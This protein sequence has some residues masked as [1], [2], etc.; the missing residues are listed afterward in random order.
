MQE[1]KIRSILTQRVNTTQKNVSQKNMNILVK[2]LLQFEKSD[3]I[4]YLGMILNREELNITQQQILNDMKN[5]HNGYELCVYDSMKEQ[6]ELEY[7]RETQP[8]K[9]VDG[10]YKCYKCNNK[11][12]STYSAQLRSADEPM[13]HF[14]TCIQCGNRW[15]G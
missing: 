8:S 9:V 3:Q 11:K 4:D 14:F 13:T 2:F 12:I 6:K 10:L 5:K 15:K 7:I 1:E